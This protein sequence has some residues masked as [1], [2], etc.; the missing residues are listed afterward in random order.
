[1]ADAAARAGEL[2]EKRLAELRDEARR[3]ERALDALRGDRRQR[4]PRRTSR[5]PS[6]QRGP[7]SRRRLS[8]K[9]RRQST[10]E[11]RK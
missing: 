10:G 8:G 6:I 5:Q 11:A 7:Q 2:I 1:M 4:A 3:L 9:A